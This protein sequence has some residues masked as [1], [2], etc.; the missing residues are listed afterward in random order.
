MSF[1]PMMCPRSQSCSPVCPCPIAGA[2]TQTPESW[3]TV[4]P[5]L[6]LVAS[7]GAADQRA[8]DLRS[9]PLK[10]CGWPDHRASADL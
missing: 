10:Y 4:K 7:D 2:G 6:A 3:S 5:P 8:G 9:H 1:P